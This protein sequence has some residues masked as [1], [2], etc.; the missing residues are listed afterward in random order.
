MTNDNN[1]LEALS[2]NLQ[3]MREVDLHNVVD[4]ILPDV[5]KSTRIVYAPQLSDGGRPD[6]IAELD[7]DLF[8]IIEVKSTTPS[9]RPRLDDVIAQLKRYAGT[10][11]RQYP[12]RKIQ[13]ILIVGSVFSQE[14]RTYLHERGIDRV[15]DGVQLASLALA[16][17]PEEPALPT[18]QVLTQRLQAVQP[19]KKDWVDYQKLIAEIVEYLFHPPLSRVLTEVANQPKTNRRDFIMPNY[20]VSGFWN[21]MRQYYDAHYV[22]GDAKNLANPMSKNAVLQVANYLSQHGVGLFGMVVTRIPGDRA[23]QVTRR[24]QWL[25]HRKLILAIDDTDIRQMIAIKASGSDPSELIRQKIEDFR[26]AI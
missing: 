19:G 5:L 8:A 2:M 13:L 24:E 7:N 16:H 1:E 21:Y 23:S 20:A 10:Y 6:F 17:P 4:R 25:Y 22:V 26:L 12:D 18:E 15:I 9:T 3:S 11:K 14:N